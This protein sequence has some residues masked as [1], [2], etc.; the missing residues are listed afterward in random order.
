[1]LFGTHRLLFC[2]AGDRAAG[3]AY[4]FARTCYGIAAGQGKTTQQS[5]GCQD[6]VSH[7]FP[8]Y[9]SV[10]NDKVLDAGKESGDFYTQLAQTG[11][12]AHQSIPGHDGTHT[13][14]GACKDDVAGFQLEQA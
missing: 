10:L 6:S 8:F 5:Q 3:P 13:F 1:M 2:S 12:R 11:N 4:I 9:K 7:D 14:R